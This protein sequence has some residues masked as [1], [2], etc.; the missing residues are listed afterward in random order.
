MED[1]IQ[2]SQSRSYSW[3]LPWP[4]SLGCFIGK[5]IYITTVLPFLDKRYYVYFSPCS[6]FFTEQYM[7]SST[8]FIALFYSLFNQPFV[9]EFPY[10]IIYSAAVNNLARTFT[11]ISLGQNSRNENTGSKRG[12]AQLCYILRFF[13]LL[14]YR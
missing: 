3:L 7:F 10:F 5:F 4:Q 6:F 12:C 8:H 9:E 1:S 11:T 2:K 13:L 14:Q